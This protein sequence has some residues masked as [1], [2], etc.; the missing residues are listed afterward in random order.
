MKFFRPVWNTCQW[1]ALVV[2][3]FVVWSL[4]LALLALLAGQIY[5]ASRSEL[6]VPDFLLR[7]LEERLAAS[8]LRADFGR[9][10]FDP[11]G[12]VLI[13]DMRV[14]LPT[15]EE[16]VL[17]AR[18]V[19]A[20]LDPWELAAGRFE[21][22]E[23]R[24][25]GATFAVPAMLSRSGGAEEILRD[26]D[27]VIVPGENSLAIT[28]L[29]AR[30]AGVAVSVH[31]SIYTPSARGTAAPPLPVA[32]FLVHNFAALCRQAD[33]AAEQL[34]ALD[35]PEL[36]LELAP[37]ESRVA[38]A[39]V[40]L[41][42]R[43]WKLAIPNLTSAS[44]PL[45]IQISNLQI[46]T[47]FPLLGDAPVA[48][49]LEFAAEELALPFNA[50]A[51]R[52]R[53]SVRGTLRPA[54]LG[55]VPRDLELSA[56]S[57]AAA[58]FTAAD[59]AARLT[60]GPLPRLE[61]DVTA[62]LMGAPLAVHTSVDFKTEVAI[63]RF[64]G[65]IAPAVLTPLSARLHADVRKFFDFTALEC[66][67]GVAELGPHWKFA[68]VSAK[69]TVQGIDAYH[70]HM[71]EG[72]AIVEFDG[73][74]FHSPEAWARI[75]ENFARGTYDHDLVTRDYRFLLDGQLRPLAIAGWFPSG[76]WT[77]FFEK[78]DFPDAPPVASVD[79]QG[80]WT[81]GRLSSEFVFADI[82]GPVFRGVKV[83][84]A[85]A[86]LFIRPE[87]FDGLEFFA[88]NG[89]GEARGKFM[90]DDHGPAGWRQ[91]DFDVASTLDLAPVTQLLGAGG[92]AIFGPFTFAQPPALKLAA[93]LDGP[94]A[95]G[96]PHRNVTIEARSA[97]EFRLHDFPLEN[98][99]FTAAVHDD[100]IAIENLRTGFASGVASG[101]VKLTGQGADRH[102]A[103]DLAM[104]DASLGRIADTLQQFSARAKG[105]PPPAPGKFVQEKAN[106]RLDLTA[107]ADGR[108]ADPF[109]YHGD[110]NATLRGP[111]LGEVPL[112]GSLS[113]LLKF[114]ALRFTSATAKFKLDGPK[115]SFSEFNLRGANSAIDSRG[116]YA[117][118]KRELDFKAK[119]F[120]FQESGNLLKNAIGAV[121]SP[122]S[123][124][125][126]VVLT[127]SLDQPHW[128]LVLGP[129][130]LL[131][132]LAPGETPPAAK[133]GE[134]ATT[135]PTAT[136]T[137]PKP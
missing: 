26:L 24:V 130:N 80:R 21:P 134:P 38:I 49:R 19:Y 41:L 121:L 70:V 34:V 135:T 48:A 86:R 23:L 14:S 62:R 128:A 73:R 39:S 37:S 92:A 63:V 32:D 89:Q 45:P 40:T 43:G 131:R 133:P 83:D 28:Q 137:E 116:D 97:G 127:G 85:R 3:S 105:L 52:V 8:G 77:R 99:A 65:A 71:E 10:S 79:V 47:R 25:T 136:A 109:S 53:A 66:A 9:T 35:Q 64:D 94:G 61:A 122:L 108:Y 2:W 78:F 123:S 124:V 72:R 98:I 29:S 118:D 44:G 115:L 91:L 125:F 132:S 113:E 90:F 100:D 82:K 95:A 58:D 33:A 13:E 42:A 31:G 36:Q 15:Y 93:H 84:R 4:W 81:E 20:R 96:G 101:R 55:F 129:T 103:F 76:W 114:T 6:E 16:P 107:S 7:R 18:A 51:H 88:T 112:L 22:R 106:V 17:R 30:I 12:R 54:Q 74:H 68:K 120:P 102:I 56:E 119:I 117:L 5:I 1:C 11:T 46:Q 57:L 27:A 126:E 69:V 60:P 87:F 59:V 110:G 67:E 111:G 75:G 104:K 50:K